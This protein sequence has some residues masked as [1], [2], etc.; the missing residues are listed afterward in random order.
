VASVAG[1]L[2]NGNPTGHD[3]L[4][5]DRS[6][7][8]DSRALSFGI[9][10][11]GFVAA[12]AALATAL[13]TGASRALAAD[14]K[15]GAADA[16]NASSS[17]ADS[18]KSSD[19]ASSDGTSSRPDLSQYASYEL[20]GD[21]VL[22]FD[23][24][25][26]P[27][28][29]IGDDGQFTGFDIELATAVCNK[30]GW[31]LKLSPIDWDA[32]DALLNSGQIT[33]IWNGF[34]IEG[35]EDDYTFTDPYMEN[36]QVIVVRGDSGITDFAGLAG[37]IV[38]AQ[39]DSAAY[40]LLVDGGEQQDLG[41][42]FGE[43]QTIGEYN[44]AFMELE[45]GMVDALAVDLPVAEFNI[46]GDTETYKILDEPLNSEHFG[47]GFKKGS[48]ELAGKVELALYDLNDDGTVKSLCDKYSDQGVSYDLWMLK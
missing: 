19:S 8:N 31:N 26:P 32:K 48:Q 4:K 28:G 13:V 38:L 10:R 27:Y 47:V 22:G 16:K 3:T 14:G 9:S 41:K 43:L 23:Q 46:G 1:L 35:R 12:S 42:T 30:Y 25:F 33:C 21:F 15:S 17:R 11:R 7:G 40:N 36:R 34:T 44:T 18:S 39:A 29:Y 5:G 20:Q 45:S 6:M 24:E 37:K 2:L